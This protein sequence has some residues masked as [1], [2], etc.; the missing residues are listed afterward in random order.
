MVQGSGLK[1]SDTMK[2]LYTIL[3][4]LVAGVSGI[5]AD[6]VKWES[7]EGWEA[8][9]GGFGNFY[10]IGVHTPG[11]ATMLYSFNELQMRFW[12]DGDE[13]SRD[14]YLAISR[15]SSES[16][17]SAN[18]VVAVSNNHLCATGNN[19]LQSFTFDDDVVLLGGTTYYLVFVQSNIP[20]NGSYTVGRNRLTLN[21]TD[22]GVYPY[23]NSEGS[24]GTNYW[25]Y[26]GATL[27]SSPATG[28]CTG[29]ILG[30][31]MESGNWKQSWTSGTT[32]SF[33]ITC[34]NA[35]FNNS[36][37]KLA[38]GLDIRSGTAYSATYTINAP[39]GY[40]V[41][42]YKLFGK[43]LDSNKD[44]TVT[45]ADGG[46]AV[47]FTSKGN[48][49][50]VSG[51]RKATT[52]FT[53]TD[54]KGNTGLFL[55]AI[56]VSLARSITSLPTENNKAYVIVNARATWNFTD[57][58]SGM[59]AVANADLDN[60]DQHIA[61]IYYKE[62]YY[63]YSVNTGKFLT[64]DNTLTTTPS[65]NDQI[66]ITA[67]GNVTYPW[68]FKFKNIADKNINVD[69]KNLIAINNWS[70]VDDGNRN[71]VI[72]VADFNPT[73]ALGLVSGYTG[74]I[75]RLK[76]ITWSD[77]DKPGQLNRY[78]LTNGFAGYAGQEW[79]MITNIEGG[80]REDFLER[81]Q[82][83]ID[84]YA[85]NMPK[86]GTFLRLKGATSGMYAK[87]GEKVNSQYPMGDADED[88]IFFYDGE[89]LLSYS[90]GIYWGATGGETGVGGSNWDWAEVGDKGS[91]VTF[92]ASNTAGRYFIKLPGIYN[93][94]P[95][96]LLYDN[97]SYCDRGAFNGTNGVTDERYTWTLEE[98]ETLPLSIA[99]DSYAS[100]SAPVPVRIPDECYAYIATGEGTNEINMEKVTG[101]VPANTGVIIYS[102]AKDPAMEIV[103][104]ATP[105]TKNNLL[106]ANVD[107][108]NISKA[109]SWFFGKVNE[110]YVFTRLSD[111]DGKDYYLLPAH[112]AYLQL[113]G[114]PARMTINWGDESTGVHEPGNENTTPQDGKY[115]R[116]GDIV[117][118]RNGIM[119]NITGQRI[120]KD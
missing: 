29:D 22:Y 84:N 42:G 66:S 9:S 60:D 46:S 52:S 97:T 33:T 19:S 34:P 16:T 6:T 103:K 25:I 15:V 4:L 100:F 55:H 38:G 91:T 86:A 109:N 48:S 111:T 101:N 115:Y 11:D 2:K 14:N 117:I 23:G 27:T 68:S 59:N 112:K 71:A 75:T 116:N 35:N 53:L 13:N 56:Q 54:N 47:T 70:T 113:D 98:V 63:L 114:N 24:T 108:N 80:Y 74:L 72:E 32:P 51:L 87:Y 107:A 105:L 49:I 26:F 64:A 50:S 82:Q 93:E 118:I 106:V 17:L 40:I 37:T 119:Y 58:A 18:H 76:E 39:E 28:Y 57:D 7:K 73:D 89:H 3:L 110:N 69:G 67:T 12:K 20:S 8:A 104:S 45:P 61:L 44:Q 90:S 95:D 5:W 78:N 81:A 43:A 77:S 99:A 36:S 10:W 88:A 30:G 1:V 83:M 41:T 92:A 21:H 102:T 96:V 31:S 94:Y 120:N 65:D 62:N 85:L 79:D